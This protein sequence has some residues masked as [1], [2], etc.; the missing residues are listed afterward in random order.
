MPT[1]KNSVIA[2]FMR[3]GGEDVI[4]LNGPNKELSLVTQAELEIITGETRML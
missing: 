1:S 4:W 2:K 3:K